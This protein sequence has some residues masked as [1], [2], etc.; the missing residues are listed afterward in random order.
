MALDP[1]ATCHL[2]RLLNGDFDCLDRLIVSHDRGPDAKLF[3]V[4]RELGRLGELPERPSVSFLDIRHLPS[5]ATAEYNRTR[6]GELA[7]LLEEWAGHPFSRSE[8]VEA[9]ALCNANRRLLKSFQ[10]LRTD[11]QP[12]FS[13]VDSLAAIGAA[14]VMDKGE[15]Q[16]TMSRLLAGAEDRSGIDG[17]RVFASGSGAE[18]ASLYRAIESAGALVVGE[19]HDFGD[20]SFEQL[21]PE[22]D[23]PLD[24]IV[25]AYGGGAPAASWGATAARAE[26][27]TQCAGRSGAE[28]VL[29]VLFDHDAAL[30]WDRSAARR[31]LA[32]VNIPLIE[33]ETPWGA[34]TEAVEGLVRSFVEGGGGVP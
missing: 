29:S 7:T 25:Q 10:S 34:P 5:H 18:D 6:I 33:I 1:I 12:R 2:V 4:L 11:A 22:T 17:V 27:T 13:G 23:D 28:A 16:A 15:Y 8:V 3:F 19:D 32:E 30:G 26:Y 20:R 14:L 21:V 24:G 9:T 31:A